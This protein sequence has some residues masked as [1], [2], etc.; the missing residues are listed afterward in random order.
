VL[1][2]H[3]LLL[4]SR[5]PFGGGGAQVLTSLALGGVPIAGVAGDQPSRF[6]WTSML[7]TRVGEMTY[8]TGAFLFTKSRRTN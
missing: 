1:P 2:G 7:P 8:G 4:C 5:T 6:I 3:F